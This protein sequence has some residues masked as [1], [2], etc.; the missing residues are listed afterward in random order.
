MELKK[1]IITTDSLTHL[2]SGQYTARSTDGKLI[3]IER[4]K[5]KGWVIRIPTQHP[6]LWEV[7]FYTENGEPDGVTY[8]KDT[9]VTEK[10]V[11]AAVRTIKQYC[12]QRTQCEGCYF[13]RNLLKN[14]SI[15][16]FMYHE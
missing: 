13:A 1:P 3:K 6:G 7:M 12:S 10:D 8:E 2:P 15:Q 5:G 11:E 16:E 9:Q 4:I 14:C